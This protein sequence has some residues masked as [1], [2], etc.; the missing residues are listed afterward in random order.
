MNGVMD[1]M[2]KHLQDSNDKFM[3]LEAKSMKLEEKMMELENE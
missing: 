1:K 3:D 2:L